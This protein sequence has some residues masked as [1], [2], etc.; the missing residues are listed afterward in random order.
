MALL[1]E[2][3]QNAKLLDELYMAFEASLLLQEM[4]LCRIQQR[5]RNYKRKNAGIPQL[6]TFNAIDLKGSPCFEFFFLRGCNDIPPLKDKLLREPPTSLMSVVNHVRTEYLCVESP[7]IDSAFKGSHRV[8][9]DPI[10]TQFFQRFLV[11]APFH[12]PESAPK[13]TR[14]LHLSRS[15][16]R[17]EPWIS[18]VGRF[19][20]MLRCLGAFHSQQHRAWGDDK[21]DAK[22]SANVE[23]KKNGCCDMHVSSMSMYTCIYFVRV[24]RRAYWTNMQCLETCQFCIM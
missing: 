6:D 20:S 3:I 14:N 8:F 19:P 15:T 9:S 10:F 11:K 17:D 12:L 16:C 22:N 7:E 1:H 5:F 21:S 23:R 24:V 18:E 2:T 4:Q 13:S